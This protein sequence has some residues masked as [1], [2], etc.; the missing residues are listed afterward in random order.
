[1]PGPTTF[2]NALRVLSGASRLVETIKVNGTL[3]AKDHVKPYGR[4][5]RPSRT[6]GLRHTCTLGLTCYSPQP[7]REWSASSASLNLPASVRQP[8]NLTSTGCQPQGQKNP[9]APLSNGPRVGMVA[10]NH[11]EVVGT[12][13]DARF[14]SKQ[15]FGVGVVGQRRKRIIRWPVSQ[16]G[17][18]RSQQ[19]PVR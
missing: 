9:H 10:M 19:S 11:P 4:D 13:E 14:L 12:D 5:F 1:M 17:R 7:Y 15:F 6:T 8:E 3:T 18:R 16:S 2:R